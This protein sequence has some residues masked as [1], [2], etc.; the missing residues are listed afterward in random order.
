MGKKKINDL[1]NVCSQCLLH[2][3]LA[4]QNKEKRVFRVVCRPLRCFVYQYTFFIARDVRANV[5]FWELWLNAMLRA[6]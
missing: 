6:R 1:Y 5:N 2:L 3:F 4:A